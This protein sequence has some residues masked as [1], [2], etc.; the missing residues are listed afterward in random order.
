MAAPKMHSDPQ[1]NQRDLYD[2]F[3]VAGRAMMGAFRNFA[4]P[5]HKLSL[6]NVRVLLCLAHPS[7]RTQSVSKLA[8]ELRWS[9]AWT[10]RILDRLMEKGFN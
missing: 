4:E 2:L 3:R 9:P 1:E 7:D 8:K 10:S 6:Q 5:P